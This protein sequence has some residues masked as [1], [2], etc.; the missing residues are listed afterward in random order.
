VADILRRIGYGSF[1]AHENL[2]AV[3]L[4]TNRLDAAI[5]SLKA[6]LEIQPM[7]TKALNDLEVAFMLS[8]RAAEGLDAF[9]RAADLEA[10]NPQ[11][12]K[13]LGQAL[14]EQSQPDEASLRLTP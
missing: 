9:Q 13:K 12:R 7:E 4:R 11:Y 10:G 8:G 2:G 6:A 3:Y 14:L 5:A 1:K